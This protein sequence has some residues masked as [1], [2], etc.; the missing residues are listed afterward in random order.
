M[1]KSLIKG[2]NLTVA[3]KIRKEIDSFIPS[4]QKKTGLNVD[5]GNAS[6][7]DDEI[8][9]KLT[10]RLAN[11]LPKEE[12]SLISHNEYRKVY[13]FLMELDLNKTYDSGNGKSY[14][15]TGYKPRAS[16]KP[17]IITDQNNN[18]F[19]ISEEQA[20]RMFGLPETKTEG[21]LTETPPPK[22]K[23]VNK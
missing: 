8:T 12:K 4:I 14:R 23:G 5:L 16:K 13:S 17:F 22:R 2:M 6:Y 9:F 3:K 1:S 19:I 20:E 11:A 10:L 7:S 21:G 15:L 18:Q